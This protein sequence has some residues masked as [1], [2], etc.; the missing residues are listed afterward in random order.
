M[1]APCA[2]GK[3]LSKPTIRE[4]IGSV[5]TSVNQALTILIAAISSPLNVSSGYYA[6]R[7]FATPLP[8]DAGEVAGCG[9]LRG[10]V[11]KI[12]RKNCE[13]CRSDNRIGHS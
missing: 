1:R 4:L 6:L 9:S 2:Q 3:L 7:D 10:R 5:N 13:E 12:R 11:K 8:W